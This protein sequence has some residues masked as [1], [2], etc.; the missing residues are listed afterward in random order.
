[1]CI[2]SVRQ[3][4]KVHYNEVLFEK[5][6]TSKPTVAMGKIAINS[7]ELGGFLPPDREEGT[8]RVGFRCHGLDRSSDLSSVAHQADH[9]FKNFRFF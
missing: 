5:C 7:G 9:F 4:I 8:R 3:H 1:M 2:I 6:I